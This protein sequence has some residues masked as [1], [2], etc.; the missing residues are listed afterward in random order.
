MNVCIF[1]GRN[2]WFGYISDSDWCGSLYCGSMCIR[3]LDFRF[4]CV[5]YDDS[6]VMFMLVSMVWCISFVL[7]VMSEGCIGI[8]IDW[9]LVVFIF[10]L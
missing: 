8:E 7:L 4:G 9:L 2:L 6:I 10:Y 3:C 1:V 5:M